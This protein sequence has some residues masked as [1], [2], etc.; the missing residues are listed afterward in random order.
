M[1]AAKRRHKTVFPLFSIILK[2]IGGER[3]VHRLINFSCIRYMEGYK[4]E[5]ENSPA[6]VSA[7]E[8]TA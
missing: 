1:T 8:E 2:G 5:I 3:M 7:N 6:S 4:T